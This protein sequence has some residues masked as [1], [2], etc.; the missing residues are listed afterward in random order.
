[1]L[2]TLGRANFVGTYLVLVI[3]LTLGHLLLTRRRWPY[4]LLII[5]QVVCLTLTQARS[6]WIGFAAAMLA[7]IIIRA[8]VQKNRRLLMVTLSLT[9][10]IIGFVVSL[11]LNP[12]IPLAQ[13]PSLNRLSHLSDPTTGSTAARITIWRTTLPLVAERPWFGYGPKTMKSVFAP[14]FPP[15]LIYYQGR[16][17]AVDRAHNLWL[18]SPAAFWI[19]LL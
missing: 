19:G 10:V 6:A 9:V 11:N 4:V 14:V 18:D 2:A 7:F 16:N 13:L 8:I 1:M 3:P 17:L 5:G 12:S 15:Q